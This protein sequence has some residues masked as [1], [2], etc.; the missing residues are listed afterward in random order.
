MGPRD[1]GTS[2]SG[3][4]ERRPSPAQ[5]GGYYSSIS[6]SKVRGCGG[7]GGRGAGRRG[8]KQDLAT[9]TTRAQDW[10]PSAQPWVPDKPFQVKMLDPRRGGAG[11]SHCMLG[12]ISSPG[13]AQSPAVSQVS[14]C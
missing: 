2:R 13:E 1:L 10:V 7:P 8:Q 4:P 11:A 6:V 14:L 5:A 12:C 3:D 9:S